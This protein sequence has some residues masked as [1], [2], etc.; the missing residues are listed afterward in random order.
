MIEE[1]GPAHQRE[2]VVQVSTADGKSARAKG[3]S[4]NSA[5]KNA[6]LE[7]I[8]LFAPK[9][10]STKSSKPQ[11]YLK[12][13]LGS[14]V[15][16][17]KDFVFLLCKLFNAEQEKAGLFSQSLT[18]PSFLN[19]IKNQNLVD[20]KKLAQ[21]GAKALE[22]LFTQQ[23][24]LLSLENPSSNEIAIEQY[25]SI[26]GNEKFSKEG[27]DLLHLYNGLLLGAGERK[28]F[29]GNP[30]S[31][32]EVF[33][34]VIGASFKSHGTWNDF[35]INLPESLEELLSQKIKAVQNAE[36]LMEFD[37]ISGL[38]VFLQAVRIEWSY[39][40][41]ISGPD[42][43][44]QYKP[45]LNLQSTLTGENFTIQSTSAYTSKK[46]ASKHI[47]NIT[48]RA[49]NIINSKF[50]VDTQKPYE[51]NTELVR[52]S[53]FLL[54]HILAVHIVNADVLRWRKLGVLGSQLL[55]QGKINE[56]KLWAIA[57]GNIIQSDDI[58]NALKLYSSIPIISEQEQANYKS[59]IES[60]GRF[61]ESLS[62]ETKVLD[63]RA[64]GEFNKLVKLSKIYKLLSQS[65]RTVSLQ[66]IIDDLFLLRRDRLP[67][68]KL[69]SE[70]PN[71]VVSEK[72]GV[73]QTMFFEMLDLIENS[74][75]ASKEY[76]L[77]IAFVFNTQKSEL[78][79]TFNF[80]NLNITDNKIQTYFNEDVLWQCLYKEANFI[81]AHF[82]TSVT[83]IT[84]KVFTPDNSFASQA[85]SAYKT[86][87]LLSKSESQIT[88]QLLHDLKNQL[89]A[90]QVSLDTAATDRTSI[91]RAKFEASQHLDNAIAIYHSL[92]VVSDSMAMP[93][94]ESIDIERFIR[95]YVSDKLT[96]LPTN[97]RL[98][99][100]KTTGSNIIYTSKS[101]LHSIFENLIKNAIEAMPNGGEI[102]IDWIYD[103]SADLLMIDIS[104][105]GS[106]L[107][108]ETLTKIKSRRVVDSSKHKG[109]GIGVLSIQSMVERL[110][111]TWSIS[112]ELGKGVQWNITI[113][114]MIQKDLAL[115]QNEDEPLEDFSSN[116]MEIE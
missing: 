55:T 93:T 97:I 109:S 79:I 46:S 86:T 73:Y 78:S 77:N 81:N 64:S 105:T 43:Q 26:L 42:H 88:S 30:A 25:R 44:K 104:D 52:F 36:S 14:P 31:K 5:S 67:E 4:K 60:I 100:P 76:P 107:S 89:I 112:S 101:F 110:G 11:V 32:A 99:M 95:S 83:Q 18:H 12:K 63:I 39:K 8:N 48:L 116:R 108:P 3:N 74:F 35:F 90:Y 50:G 22:A 21:L 28:I 98:E 27:F 92:E 17:H 9:L 33:Q 87:S 91:L 20:N 23:I 56:F 102:R 111:G 59:D 40:F 71:I 34:A 49:I 72:E 54:N 45:I 115:S 82:T 37:P 62:P 80:K 66:A 7:Y 58:T 51:D 103:D 70:V 75:P 65:W 15:N 24:A 6:A 41:L 84:T 38:H 1:L 29:L 113:P 68:I 96:K 61:I 57:T 47:A 69:S 19:E 106:G 85:L 2:F 10:L 16:L 94:M 114:S 13:T 53:L